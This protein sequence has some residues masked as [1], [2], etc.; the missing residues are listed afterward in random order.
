MVVGIGILGVEVPDDRPVFL[1]TLAVHVAAGLICV[2]AGP[3]R[4]ARP[5]VRDA[6]PAP[7]PST[8]GAWL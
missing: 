6:I 7:A 5:S 1:T 4:R 3:S 2:V 8:C